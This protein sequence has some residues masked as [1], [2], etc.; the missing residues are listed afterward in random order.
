VSNPMAGTLSNAHA[1][2]VL[3]RLSVGSRNK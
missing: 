2:R 1:S 3:L